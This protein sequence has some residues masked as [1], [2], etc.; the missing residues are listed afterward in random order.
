MMNKMRTIAAGLRSRLRAAGSFC[1]ALMVTSARC[2]LCTS[3]NRKRKLLFRRRTRPRRNGIRRAEGRVEPGENGFEI[4]HAVGTRCAGRRGIGCERR[5]AGR[6][7][8]LV[9]IV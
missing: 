8:D 2:D 5:I 9:G 4:G 6:L 1:R 7:A 3:V